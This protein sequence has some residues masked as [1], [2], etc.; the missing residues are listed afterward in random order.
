MKIRGVLFDLDGVIC[1]TARYHFL[2]WKK[3]ANHLGGD[4]DEEFNEQL[5]GVSREES[6]KLILNR[7]NQKLDSDEFT[8]MTL[9]KN[10]WYLE[11]LEQLSEKDILPGIEEFIVQLKSKEIKMAITSSSQ[12]A[13]FILKKIGLYE[14]FD[15]IVD[16]KL[17]ENN[18]P[19]PDIFIEGAKQININAQ[20]CI[21]I[22]DSQ[23]G[24]DALNKANIKSIAIGSNLVGATITLASTEDLTINKWIKNA[25]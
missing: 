5:K 8:K 7:I 3:L 13:P 21:G 6:L 23:A 4:I 25:S 12:N 18:K 22:E 15:A 17:I 11:M 16:S 10:Q 2:A 19:E 20:E 24:I 14:L 9:K 1:D